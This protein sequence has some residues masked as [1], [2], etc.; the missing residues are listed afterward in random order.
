LERLEVYNW[1]TLH[2]SVWGLNCHGDN[3]LLTGDIGSGKSTL[4]DAISTLLIAPQKITYNKAA[5]ADARERTPRTYVL[6]Y[7]KSERGDPGS[8]AKPIPLRDHNQY[9]VILGRFANQQLSQQ[10]TVAQVFWWKDTSGQPAR[11]YV[12]AD[13]P[14]SIAQDFSTFGN[15]ERTGNGSVLSDRL[16][17]VGG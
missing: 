4:V 2:R 15:R 3:A 10:V 12:V 11:F 16:D 14:L 5:G 8:A 7:Y 9:S 1:G 6:G 13:V 17:E